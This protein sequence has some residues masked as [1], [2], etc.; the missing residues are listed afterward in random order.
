[1]NE[2]PSSEPG[3]DDPEYEDWGATRGHVP[4]GRIPA[5]RWP[6]PPESIATPAPPRATRRD[7]VP[8]G[9]RPG[10]REKLTAVLAAFRDRRKRS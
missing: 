7:G 6:A 3:G 2:A 1:M 9:D 5:S 8:A 4:D 10:P